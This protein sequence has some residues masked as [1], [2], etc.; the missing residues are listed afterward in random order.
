M[1]VFILIGLALLAFS[2]SA[3]KGSGENANVVFPE[4]AERVSDRP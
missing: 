2:V 1:K 4:P 3:E